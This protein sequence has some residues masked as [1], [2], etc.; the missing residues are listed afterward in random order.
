[1]LLVV[2]LLQCAYVVDLTRVIQ[3][4]LQHHKDDP[5][6]LYSLPRMVSTRRV[7]L[8]VVLEPVLRELRQPE[9]V[10]F[11]DLEPNPA[12]SR[13]VRAL[14]AAGRPL[15]GLVPAAVAALIEANRLYREG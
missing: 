14:A 13:D 9:R 5:A 7:Q 11:F 6:C 3:I 10:L 8:G 1:M 15:A 2:P 12:S 4:M